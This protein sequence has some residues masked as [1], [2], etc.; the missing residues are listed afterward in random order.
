MPH[1]LVDGTQILVVTNKLDANLQL[2]QVLYLRRVPAFMQRLLKLLLA[3]GRVGNVHP[4]LLGN[5]VGGGF[6]FDLRLRDGPSVDRELCHG[7]A[8][9]LGQ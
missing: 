9:S 1:E 6:F 8:A 7:Y 2:M 3:Y 5:I 4:L